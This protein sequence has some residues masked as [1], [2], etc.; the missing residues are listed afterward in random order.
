MSA[1]RASRQKAEEVD[2]THRL[3]NAVF[4]SSNPSARTGASGAR[5]VA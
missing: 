5:C 3:W 4:S 1:A 2:G